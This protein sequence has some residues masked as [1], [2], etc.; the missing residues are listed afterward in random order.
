MWQRKQK[1][2]GALNQPQRELK[3]RY[4]MV[5]YSKS[6]WKTNMLK[7]SGIT[8]NQRRPKME[9]RIIMTV[10]ADAA[11]KIG[12]DT[13]LYAYPLVLMDVTRKVQ[14]NAETPDTK[15][16]HAPMNQF[17]HAP[18]FPDA[19]FTDVVR[20]NADTLYSFL[21]FD[22]SK[23]PLVI[24][25]PDSGG[26]YY[27]LPMLDM[28]TDIFASPGKRTSGTGPQTY[29]ITGPGWQGK[30]P[31][32]VTEIKAPTAEGWMIGRTQTNGKKD[33][34][35]VHQFQA[36]LKVVPL[37][38][39]GKRGWTPPKGRV[40]AQQDMSAPVE[41]VAKMSAAEFF[42]DFAELMK[43]NPPH[44]NDYPILQQMERLGIVPGE[45]FD[46]S[47]ASPETKS[48]LEAAP[49]AGMAKIKAY[50]PHASV[51]INNWGMIMNP[52]GT[53]GTDYLKRAFIAYF[54]L[55]A[56]VV[57]D[58]VYPSALVDAHGKP[59]FD[60][61]M[62]YVLHFEKEQI[63]PVRAFWSLTLY[64]DKQF[65]ADNPINRY[66]IGD[67]D[68]LK[69]NADGSLNLYIQC[70]TPGADKEDNWLPAPKEGG[71]SLTLRLYWPQPTVLDGSWQPPGVQRV[72]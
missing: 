26:R 10:T 8:Y 68:N 5:R 29:A 18:E 24:D 61:G 28:W 41:Q 4:L 42:A 32:D 58:A 30:L 27:L 3:I 50:A 55:G 39:W 72:P 56:N 48:A 44:A 47:K 14:S 6:S 7:C 19:T 63:P 11:K 22:V 69:F 53:Y 46:L 45:S 60:S 17:Y 13:Y 54:G 66:A 65:F 1:I 62:K 21:W 36:G 43:A 35:A 15:T 64:N 33:Y 71:F 49:A 25:V 57:E 20:A 52:V 37:S 2:N 40:D 59:L 12:I 70:D 38:A 51:L 67:R 16:K 31:T 34:D 9:A 23:E